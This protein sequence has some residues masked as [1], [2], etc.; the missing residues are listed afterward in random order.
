MKL[1]GELKF[2][3][4]VAM[5]RDF[6]QT[7]E[8]PR[9]RLALF[10]VVMI[11]LATLLL[12][13]IRPSFQP[14]DIA[15][16]IILVLI[17]ALFMP[18]IMNQAAKRIVR[19]SGNMERLVPFTID[20]TDEGIRVERES[21]RKQVSWKEIHQVTSDQDHIFLYYG[22]RS[23]IIIPKNA[24]PSL[25]DLNKL[26]STYAGNAM[27]RKK[28]KSGLTRKQ[29]R[30]ILASLGVGVV[31]LFG[32]NYY[33]MK[34]EYDVSRATSA[35]NDLFI[36][37]D[38]EN[39]ENRIKDTTNQAQ[40]D[41]AIKALERIEINEKRYEIYSL[42]MLGLYTL[43]GEAQKQLNERE[44]HHAPELTDDEKVPYTTNPDLSPMENLIENFPELQGTFDEIPW[45]MREKVL[46]P[47]LEDFPF[48]VEEV[49]IDHYQSSVNVSYAGEG[50]L[51]TS[52][53][54]YNEEG[55]SH[56]GEEVQ[57]VNDTVGDLSEDQ[58]SE[59]S[60]SVD[61]VD[62]ENSKVLYSAR[63]VSESDAANEEV[64]SLANAMIANEG[65]TYSNSL[66]AYT[67]NETDI[68][69]KNDELLENKSELEDFIAVAGTNSE[70]HIRIVKWKPGQGVIIYDLQ[71]RYDQNQDVG[72]IDVIPDLTYYEPLEDEVPD[73][74]N[75]APQQCGSM[76]KD[77]EEGFYKLY[78]CRTN[79]EYRILPVVEDRT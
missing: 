38:E 65:N 17:F 16:N 43:V 12:F 62:L 13:I 11:L 73:V 64:I 72:W 5:Q 47:S 55:L 30:I 3:N 59:D 7:L 1:E 6:Q 76:F 77:S 36:H 67:P 2:E 66:V 52:S 56:R 20:L 40:I 46:L 28:K 27:N 29:R 33:L 32:V 68:V 15:I 45:D 50:N 35:V 31:L 24:V 26:L 4:L 34:P 42:P 71:S 51:F 37:T 9:K 21:D 70:S 58:F 19:K 39:S 10:K 63:L 57:L 18:V 78:E 8:K 49:A 60:V 25:D 48:Y 79:L 53:V 61:W 69:L 75:Q 22:E 23:A 14:I 41:N 54:R 74:F 44:G